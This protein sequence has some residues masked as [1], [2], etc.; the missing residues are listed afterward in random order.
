MALI[1]IQI[2]AQGRLGRLVG[3]GDVLGIVRARRVVL[4]LMV[5]KVP[6]L[7]S[8]VLAVRRHGRPAQ[9]DGQQGKQQCSE[10]AAHARQSISHG[11]EAE[12]KPAM[13]RGLPLATA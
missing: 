6:G 9:L 1:A 8:F 10:P 13:G 7:R 4:M 11:F 5:A 2:D 3:T 12:R